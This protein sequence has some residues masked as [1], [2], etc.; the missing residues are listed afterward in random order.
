MIS[1]ET[2]DTNFRIAYP[3]TKPKIRGISDEEKNKTAKQG[4]SDAQFM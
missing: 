4:F 3:L 1:L 2:V